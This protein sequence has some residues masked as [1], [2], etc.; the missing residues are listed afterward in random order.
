MNRLTASTHKIYPFVVLLQ[1][2]KTTDCLFKV[3]SL[4]FFLDVRSLNWFL[5]K[6]VSA[7]KRSIFAA[8]PEKLSELPAI[9]YKIP[10][11]SS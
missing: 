7:A 1:L 5:R 8:T 6:F 9:F 2:W 10:D 3:H 11:L 4:P